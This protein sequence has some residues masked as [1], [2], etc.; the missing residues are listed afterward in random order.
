MR[1]WIESKSERKEVV[2]CW[3]A[4]EMYAFFDVVISV[5]MQRK[6]LKLS[7]TAI[8]AL[9]LDKTPGLRDGRDS[10]SAMRR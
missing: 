7:E 3:L 4:E 2:V 5:S 8:K 6:G 10:C 9:V 1:R